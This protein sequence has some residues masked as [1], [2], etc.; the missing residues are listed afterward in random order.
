MEVDQSNQMDYRNR[1]VKLNDL[2]LNKLHV[3]R[4]VAESSSM[5]DAGRK[6]LR[7]PSAI[8]QSVTGLERSLGL[9]LFVRSGIRLQLTD[10]GRRL[11]E[12]VKENEKGLH[13]ILE[14]VRA[15]PELV[16]GRVNL[17][18]PHGYPAVSLGDRLASTLGRYQE[19]QLRLRFLSHTDLALGLMGN[20]LE[21][22]L[23]LQPLKLW[24]RRIKSTKLRQEHLILAVPAQFRHLC[25]APLTELPVVDYYQKPLL[26]EG[27]LKHH[28][29]RKVSTRIRVFGSNLEHV[30]QMVLAG[31]GCAVV[32][33]HLVEEYLAQGTL[34]E[35]PLDKRRPWIESVWLNST[36]AR[37]EFS[38]ATRAVWDS[39]V[40]RR[41]KNRSIS[42]C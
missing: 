13:S 16:R 17:G 5:R 19:L 33:R 34:L 21:I 18:M 32:P 8:S 15:Q 26:I 1:L 12:Q 37:K 10:P 9:Q 40:K 27:W 31:V 22:A 3:F 24:N 39:F 20:E 28:R 36:R 7:T 6:L 2:D 23:S 29:K 38:L 4:V 11:L 14:R 30:L 25:S 42:I 35:H 41:L